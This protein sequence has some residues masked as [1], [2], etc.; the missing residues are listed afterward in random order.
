M[1]VP[2]PGSGGIVRAWRAEDPE[3]RAGGQPGCGPLRHRSPR[4]APLTA[5][6]RR[7]GVGAGGA[8]PARRP[9][10]EGASGSRSPLAALSSPSL[11]GIPAAWLS[12]PQPP[13]RA[14]P[15]CWGAKL[16]QA[17]GLM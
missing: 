7:P 5:E 15:G 12:C 11:L 6:P 17:E 14:P 16:G 10:W 4:G 1:T 8:S 9:R 13:A 3:G 2:A